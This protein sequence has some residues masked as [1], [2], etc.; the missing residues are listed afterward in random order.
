MLWLCSLCWVCL[1]ES[2]RETQFSPNAMNQYGLAQDRRFPNEIVEKGSCA[3]QTCVVTTEVKATEIGVDLSLGSGAW[4]WLRRV[5]L[6]R[7][8][9]QGVV[10]KGEYQCHTQ[11]DSQIAST[12]VANV[13]NKVHTVKTDSMTSQTSSGQAVQEGDPQK[14]LRREILPEGRIGEEEKIHKFGLQAKVHQRVPLEKVL[15][16]PRFKKESWPSCPS[17]RH[18]EKPLQSLWPVSQVG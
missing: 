11:W 12:Q 18:K 9:H 17:W 6:V 14:R 2:L 10:K 7:H 5:I 8:L 16:V 3:K 15:E 1:R 4:Q 13:G